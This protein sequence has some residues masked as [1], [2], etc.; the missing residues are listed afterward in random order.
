[1]TPWMF[2]MNKKSVSLWLNSSQENMFYEKTHLINK[3]LVSFQNEQIFI[4]LLSKHPLFYAIK[5][6][7]FLM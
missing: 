7:Y 3:T 4:F 2:G 5:Y 6:S 1:M